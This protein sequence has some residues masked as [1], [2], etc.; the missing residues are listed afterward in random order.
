[1]PVNEKEK[2]KKHII[3]PKLIN[4][5]Q[6]MVILNKKGRIK[7]EEDVLNWKIVYSKKF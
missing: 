4:F 3:L 2:V 5:N 1:M 7:K 6:L